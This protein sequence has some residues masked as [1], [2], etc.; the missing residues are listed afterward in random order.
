MRGWKVRQDMSNWLEDSLGPAP[1]G[2]TEVQWGHKHVL[3]LMEIR[4]N[5]LARAQVMSGRK[6]GKSSIRKWLAA[7]DYALKCWASFTEDDPDQGIESPA[8]DLKEDTYTLA[9]R[10]R[11]VLIEEGTK[12]VTWAMRLGHR[13][14]ANKM[15]FY[16]DREASEIDRIFLVK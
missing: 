6:P 14:D 12:A 5:L 16:L 10:H 1:E 15:M 8:I 13:Q 11:T 9:M 4:H 3:R 7:T 2:W